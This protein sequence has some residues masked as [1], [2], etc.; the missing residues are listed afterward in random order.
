MTKAKLAALIVAGL[1]AAA[2]ASIAAAQSTISGVV[3]DPTGAV[4][5]G[6]KVEAASDVL[7]ERSRAVLTSSDGRYAIVDLRPGLYTMTF[8][9]PGFSTIKQQVDLPANVTVTVD[10]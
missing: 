6:V 5:S 7:I 10:A 3:R 8:T 9:L 1:I 2:S 4:M